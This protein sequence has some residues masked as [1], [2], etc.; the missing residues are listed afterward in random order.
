MSLAEVGWG[1]IWKSAS[2]FSQVNVGHDDVLVTF[3]TAL[4][5]D[6]LSKERPYLVIVMF[7]KNQILKCAHFTQNAPKCMH[8]NQNTPK[9][10]HFTKMHA[11]YSKCTKI[12]DFQ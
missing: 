11:F 2:T 3:F 4:R 12:L 7:Q 5:F 6:C 10:A 9:C 8:F 1:Y